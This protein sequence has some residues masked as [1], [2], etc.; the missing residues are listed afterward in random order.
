MET[1]LNDKKY[2]QLPLGVSGLGG[3]L[4]LVQIGLYFTVILLI[5]QIAVYSLPSF[6]E[7]N[8]RVLTSKESSLYDP[9]WKPLIV[10][11]TVYNLLFLIFTVYIIVLFYRKKSIVPRLMIIFYSA[12]LLVGIM[13]Y[14]LL[15]QIALAKEIEDGSS[16]RDLVRSGITCLVWIPYFIKSVRVRNTFVN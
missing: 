15:Q 9:L 16:V 12:S 3:W 10:F 5:I 4:I 1:S 6:S 7:E 11:E 2:D 14:I 13:D 8:W